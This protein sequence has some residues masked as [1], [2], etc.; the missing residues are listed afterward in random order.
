VEMINNK[1]AKKIYST[2]SENWYAHLLRGSP[3]VIKGIDETAI[4]ETVKI[5][6]VGMRSHRNVKISNLIK[7]SMATDSMV[8]YQV[9]VVLVN[10]MSFL[11][12]QKEWN[13]CGIQNRLDIRDF[14]MTFGI[15]S[16]CIGAYDQAAVMQISDD[17]VTNYTAKFFIG[18]KIEGKIMNVKQLDSGFEP[19]RSMIIFC[20]D[21]GSMSA[22]T[23]ISKFPNESFG[24]LVSLGGLY[25]EYRKKAFGDSPSSE[26]S[27]EVLA[28]AIA[29]KVG[30]ITDLPELGTVGGKSKIA[31]IK[32][33]V[34]K[35]VN[36]ESD[37]LW[38][39]G[40]EVKISQME[41][42]QTIEES[43][44]EDCFLMVR[45]QWKH[46]VITRA[47]SKR[48]FDLMEFSR[49]KIGDPICSIYEFEDQFYVQR[50]RTKERR[51]ISQ[52]S[53]FDM[54]A[55]NPYVDSWYLFCDENCYTK[56]VEKC[57]QNGQR[58]DR[59]SIIIATPGI[60]IARDI[61][62]IVGKKMPNV[63]QGIINAYMRPGI[64]R[65]ISSLDVKS[66]EDVISGIDV[67]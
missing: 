34:A 58:S 17:V 4:G 36:I 47:I 20:R 7:L 51:W 55:D 26:N 45:K 40:A 42:L 44:F 8:I 16:F 31:D 32:L 60:N 49:D 56:F 5:D 53:L 61:E 14:M 41:I 13:T 62:D 35:I 11:M 43:S 19:E 12:T 23:G 46:K 33:N 39:F 22:K 59:M 38:K 57:F 63:Q 3:L 64:P 15:K 27:N 25:I 48:I 6:V 28:R 66:M 52:S 67:D 65:T 1:M 54:I 50:D 2:E 24:G 10:S 30:L 29:S 21:A 18:C 37:F 9:S